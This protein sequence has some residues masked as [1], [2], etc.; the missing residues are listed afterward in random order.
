MD[1]KTDHVGWYS[2]WSAPVNRYCKK[3]TV[4]HMIWFTRQHLAWQSRVWEHIPSTRCRRRYLRPLLQRIGRALLGIRFTDE[5]GGATDWTTDQQLATH[6]RTKCKAL[7]LASIFDTRSEGHFC[8]WSQK[9]A[10]AWPF[11]P[12]F[13][14][15]FRKLMFVFSTWSQTFLDGVLGCIVNFQAS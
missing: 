5:N 4:F 3:Y 15:I 6:L 12:W 2:I 11:S 8:R 13:R 14:S 10:E 7:H 9:W 1:Y